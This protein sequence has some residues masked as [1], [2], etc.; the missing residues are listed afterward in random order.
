MTE[1]EPWTG[2]VHH[3]DAFHLLDELPAESVHAVVTDPPYGMAFMPDTNEWDEFGSPEEYERWCERWGRNVLRVLKP[4]G[5]AAVCGG[6]RTHHRLYCGL[7][8]AGF[9]I[10]HTLP[11]L[12]ADNFPKSD[13]LLKPGAEFPVLARKPLAGPLDANMDA[14]GVGALNVDGCRIPMP[15]DGGDGNWAGGEEGD[16][17]VFYDSDSGFTNRV[18]EQPDG[19][20]P[21]T[22]TLDEVAAAMLD[23]QTGRLESGTT[24]S[25]RHEASAGNNRAY[26]ERPNADDRD[27]SYYGDA[28]GAS[29]FFY[30]AKATEAERTL[31]GRIKNDHAT[32]KPVD[33]IEWHV[34][35]VTWPGQVVLD[36]FA[37]SGTTGIACQRQ[38][39]RFVLFE[40]QAAHHAVAQARCGVDVDRP[41]LLHADDQP[42]LRAFT[43]GGGD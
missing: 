31:N 37:G 17:G 41:D 38:D 20:Y 33:L 11:W 19:R 30:V 39:R 29:R 43:D 14:H 5:H 24:D 32:V 9:E 2:A 21:A 15:D 16:G 40:K 42:P 26:G 34:R 6:D 3:G 23:A 25:S 7:E 12:F 18:S 36:P 27:E 1:L 4:G 13:A 28:G 8:D 10:R 22:V 35:L